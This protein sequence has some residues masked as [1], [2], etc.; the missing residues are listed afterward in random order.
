MM[1]DSEKS[2]KLL[3]SHHLSENHR[4]RP[5]Q[6]FCAFYISPDAG[7]FEFRDDACH[8]RTWANIYIGVFG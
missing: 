3:C 8:K 7:A 6:L 2:T 4:T 5:W 1:E